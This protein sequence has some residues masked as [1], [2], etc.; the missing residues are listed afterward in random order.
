MT[1][2]HITLTEEQGV[3]TLTLN[4]ARV[5][6]ALSLELVTET[7]DAV[8]RVRDTGTARV[9]LMTGAPKAR[10]RSRSAK[11]RRICSA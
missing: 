7:I 11:W 5:L 9:L 10:R 8:D 4:R 3:A 2:E 6:N 1:Y